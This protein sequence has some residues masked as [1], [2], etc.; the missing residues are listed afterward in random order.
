MCNLTEEEAEQA[1]V[2]LERYAFSHDAPLGPDEEEASELAE[3]LRGADNGNKDFEIEWYQDGPTTHLT[4]NS[5]ESLC[6]SST[7]PEHV[8]PKELGDG[9]Y[10][11]CQRCASIAEQW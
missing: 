9:D 11:L 10:N 3:K 5:K 2:Y 4:K 1:A 6:G 7:V 8:V